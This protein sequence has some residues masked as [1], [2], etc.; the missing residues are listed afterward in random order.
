[1]MRRNP[2]WSFPK[3]HITIIPIIIKRKKYSINIQSMNIFIQRQWVTRIT[4]D[5]MNVSNNEVECNSY[6]IQHWVPYE[7]HHRKGRHWMF[8]LFLFPHAYK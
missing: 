7:Q 8:R 2:I 4:L 1:L 5:S 6:S 3:P